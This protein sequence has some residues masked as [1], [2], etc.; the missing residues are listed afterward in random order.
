[1]A[2]TVPALAALRDLF[3]APRL[4]TDADQRAAFGH[5]HSRCVGTPDA[6]VLPTTHAEVEAL[7]RLCRTH[8]IALTARGGGTSSTGAAVPLA[9][10]IV[11]SFEHMQRVLRIDPDNRLAVVEPGVTNGTLQQALAPHGFFWAPDPGSAPWCTVGGNLA[12]NAGGPH[13]VKYGTT[14]DNVLGLR[15]VAGTG[16][17]FRCGTQ[18]TKDSTGYDLTRLL[19]GSEGTLAV[20]TE[21]TLKLTPKPPAVRSLRASYASPD[22]AAQA[23]ARIMAQATTPCALEFMDALALR[24]AR[25]THPDAGVPDAEALLIIEVDGED[26]TID[27][28]AAAVAR[29]ARGAGLEALHVA[30]DAGENAALWAARKA[31][32]Q[33]QQQVTTHKINEDVVVPVS[34]L[35]E[36]VRGVHALA[37]R[38]TVPVVSFG[39]AGNGNLHVNFLPRDEA[40]IA[41]AE[42]ALPELFQLVVALDG[43][44]SGEHGIGRVK[45]DYLPLA[46]DAGALGLMHAVKA[47]FDPD[48]ILNPGKVLP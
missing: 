46:V 10:G 20:I 37:Q 16:A 23:V 33:A 9:G 45:R 19:V 14:R 24:L 39:H 5:D 48:G 38:H 35:P 26:A 34:R 4:V 29:A 30:R 32:S 25:D 13:A 40:E 36:L 15:A 44:L 21:A 1:M 31:L 12:C 18:T 3:P 28:A 17:G 47:A 8:R 41:R 6:V 7:V 43:T 22:A 27:V 42:T 2:L 11:A